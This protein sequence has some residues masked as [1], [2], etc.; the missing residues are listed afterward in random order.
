MTHF[1]INKLRSHAPVLKKARRWL[2]PGSPQSTYGAAQW[3]HG[4]C[5]YTPVLPRLFTVMPGNCRLRHA[6]MPVAPRLRPG[7][8][9][10]YNT[11]I[12]TL[13]REHSGSVV[14]CLTRDREFEPCRRHCVV[15]LEHSL[16]VVQSRK[17]HPRLTERLLMERKETNQTKKQKRGVASVFFCL[18]R[19]S[20]VFKEKKTSNRHKLDCTATYDSWRLS[21]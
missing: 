11:R 1:I 7:V 13:R 21:Y 12:K 16:V 18:Y 5:R 4:S 14:Q 9:L 10:H 8:T 15:V 6:Y 19:I 17:T 3:S 20:Y 2:I